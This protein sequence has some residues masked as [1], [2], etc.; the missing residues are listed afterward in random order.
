[1]S[2][3]TGECAAWVGVPL[4]RLSRCRDISTS[5]TAANPQNLI[6]K[7]RF[8]LYLRIWYSSFCELCRCGRRWASAPYLYL[9]TVWIMKMLRNIFKVTDRFCSYPSK[10]MIWFVLHLVDQIFI[11]STNCRC[12]ENRP[13]YI[14][15]DPSPR[16]QQKVAIIRRIQRYTLLSWS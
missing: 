6:L 2:L 4:P 11:S 3:F 5:I 12:C 8:H 9:S 10:N 7:L 15:S 1:M 13:C 16:G 14:S